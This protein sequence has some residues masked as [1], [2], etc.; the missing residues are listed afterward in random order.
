[1]LETTTH[2]TAKQ[3]QKMVSRYVAAVV[4]CSF[5]S[6]SNKTSYVFYYEAT[7]NFIKKILNFFFY[8]YLFLVGFGGRG[9][10]DLVFGFNN[11]TCKLRCSAMLCFIFGWSKPTYNPSFLSRG[12]NTILVLPLG[13]TPHFLFYFIQATTHGLEGGYG[14]VEGAETAVVFFSHNISCFW[15]SSFHP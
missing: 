2:F 8:I 7:W 1:M 4:H 14:M 13:S 11:P 12:I 6:L 10:T 3:T 5:T 9:L 15:L